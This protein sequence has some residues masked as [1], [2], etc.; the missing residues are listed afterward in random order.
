MLDDKERTLLSSLPATP[1]LTEHDRGNASLSLNEPMPS[2]PLNVISALTGDAVV[3]TFV[4]ALRRTLDGRGPVLAV[5]E[6]TAPSVAKSSGRPNYGHS[7]A[8]ASSPEVSGGLPGHDPTEID[9]HELDDIAVVIGT[10]GSTGEP[11]NVLLSASALRESARATHARLGGPGRWLLA[12]SPNRIAG[13]QV[14]VRSIEAGTEPVALDTR[15]TPDAF[16]DATAHLGTGRRYT[17]LVPTQLARLLDA[18][19]AVRAALAS[20][21]AVLLGGAATEPT[22]LARAAAAGVSVHR[23]YGMTESAGGCVYDGVPLDKV[24]VRLGPDGRVHLTGPVLFSGYLGRPDLTRQALVD[25]WLVTSDLGEFD[26][27]GRLE[28]LGRADDM[29]ISGG[30]NVPPLAVERALA[31][32]PA[33]AEAVVVGVPDSEWGQRVVAFVVPRRDTALSVDLVRDRLA[34]QLPKAYVPKEFIVLAEL[35]TL[36]SGKPDRRGLVGRYLAG[37]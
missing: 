35:P 11:K 8:S 1:I 24:R 33:I 12:L 30:V 31:A 15:F 17:S 32:L 16:A 4:P 36:P 13:L 10:S 6:E 27:D 25:G 23:T 3:A 19:P 7:R 37:S 29:I 9:G 21:D 5:T 20:Y 28:I 34:E 14:L 26:A 18:G 2:R 22:L